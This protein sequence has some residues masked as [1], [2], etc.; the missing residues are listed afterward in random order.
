MQRIL[1]E[2]RLFVMPD[3]Y[4]RGLG[5]VRRALLP[6]A[7]TFVLFFALMVKTHRLKA[8]AKVEHKNDQHVRNKRQLHFPRLFSKSP[9]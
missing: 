1:F 5:H 9:V 4:A 7:N 2:F 6:L 8:I 3:Q